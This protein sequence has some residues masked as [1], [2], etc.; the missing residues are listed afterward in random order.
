MLTKSYNKNINPYKN[1]L[2]FVLFIF[3]FISSFTPLYPNDLSK[4]N[5]YDITTNNNSFLFFLK[6]QSQLIY[7]HQYL[8]VSKSN[9]IESK[10]KSDHLKNWYRI[11]DIYSSFFQFR[12]SS[13][14]EQREFLGEKIKDVI[15]DLD[16]D[17]VK[18]LTSYEIKMIKAVLYGMSAY[19]Y[20]EDSFLSPYMDG[21]KSLGLFDE[22]KQDYP[23]SIDTEFGSSMSLMYKPLF[24]EDNFF[25]SSL[26][27]EKGDLAKGLYKLDKLAFNGNVTM[28]ESNFVLID[29]YSN[30]LQDYNKANIYT[31]NLMQLSNKNNYYFSFLHAKN[32]FNLEQYEKALEL[33]I[34][35]NND[36]SNKFYPYNYNSLIYEIKCSIKLGKNIRA[37]EGINLLSLISSSNE[38][39]AL[40]EM[41]KEKSINIVPNNRNKNN[42]FYKAIQLFQSFVRNEEYIK[43][44]DLFQSKIENKI[45]G[46]YD[47]KR[48]KILYNIVINNL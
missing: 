45:D 30:L 16:D 22:L 10:K 26:Y 14:K 32:L 38:I 21:K 17:K 18:N 2:I 15:D 35:I 8:Q 34:S 20:V 42:R 11:S 33:F 6:E 1:N 40:K 36:I 19:I 4:K 28:I 12:L 25:V 44:Y 37:E 46:Y 5:I 13:S 29:F 48:I 3:F 41:L 43:A 7:T 47:H 9:K 39:I 31:T 27:I 24:F 23:E